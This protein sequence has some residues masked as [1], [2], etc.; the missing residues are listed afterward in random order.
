VPAAYYDHE[1]VLSGLVHVPRHHPPRGTIASTI[2][3]GCTMPTAMVKVPELQ[4][5]HT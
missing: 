3:V 1:L 2:Q 4:L 5:D